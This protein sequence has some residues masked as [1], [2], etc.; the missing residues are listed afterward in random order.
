MA[1]DESFK[2]VT[3]Y[4]TKAQLTGLAYQLMNERQKARAAF[5]AA[6]LQLENELKSRPKDP[7][8]HA[9]FGLVYA[10][11][12][13]K[14][15]AI[16]EGTI[17]TKLYP[18]SLDAFQGPEYV[19]NLALIYAMLGESDA[20]FDQIEYV[21]SIP[22]WFS[23]SLLQLDPRWDPIRNHPRYQPIVQKYQHH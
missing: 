18:V 5:E 8:I 22:S 15:E 16:Q 2:D 11:L 20:A 7:R 12:E 17:A 4:A 3:L 1:P 9:A 21:L 10:G 23:V 19:T 13:R 6:R 14:K